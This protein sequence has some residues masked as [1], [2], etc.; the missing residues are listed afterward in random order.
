MAFPVI[1]A[2]MLE[3][4]GVAEPF[5]TRPKLPAAQMK[6]KFEEVV[7]DVAIPAINEISEKLNNGQ[8]AQDM[9][10]RDPVTQVQAKLQEVLDALKAYTDQ[11]VVA[12][13]AGDMAMAVYD[14]NN[15]AVAAAGGID[16][17]ILAKLDPGGQI[18][19]AGSVMD[20]VH[21]V[22]DVCIRMDEE[23]PGDL[24]GGTWELVSQGRMLVGRDPAAP[25]FDT[26]GKTG[27]SKLLQS[28]THVGANHRHT[29]PSHAHTFSGSTGGGGAHSHGGKEGHYFMMWGGSGTNWN[30]AMGTPGYI[31]SETSAVS[32]HTH[33]FSGTTAAN[34]TGYTGYATGTTGSAG[35]GDAQNM[36]PYL[37]CNIWKRVA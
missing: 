10:A 31:S 23:D 15:G 4:K 2:S 37:V 25:E 35:S 13:G 1:T 5:P 20:A 12:I 7:R 34:G 11:K 14:K 22:G 30:Q 36:P 18:A 21:P 24:Y 29:G 32:N 28:H 17:Y 16:G 27:G 3:G 19:T 8:G 26:V 33:T 6:E 9:G